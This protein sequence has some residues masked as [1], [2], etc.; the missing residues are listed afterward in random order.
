[1]P[2]LLRHPTAAQ[3]VDEL[4]GASQMGARHGMAAEFYAREYR[5]FEGGTLNGVQ[6]A[7]ASLAELLGAVDGA[8]AGAVLQ[9]L[10]TAVLPVADK[11]LVDSTL[12][13]RVLA[14]FMAAA[15]ASVV[16][17]AVASLSGEPLLHMVHTQHGATAAA[18]VFA[19]G[20]PRDRKKAVRALKGHVG[21]M[22][23]DEWGHLPLITCLSVVDDTSLLRKFV[24]SELMV[25]GPDGEGELGGGGICGVVVGFRDFFSSAAPSACVRAL[26][27][28]HTPGGCACAARGR[29]LEGATGGLGDDQVSTGGL[30]PCD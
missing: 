25:R 6:G 12:V 3:V 28:R 1:M 16:A 11:A 22:A 14:E 2:E 7:P 10:S 24:A 29:L 21:D 15:P 4:Y 9:H 8:K 18:A 26:F 13:H 5:L 23:R 30:I 19:Y 27:R 17:D 20:T